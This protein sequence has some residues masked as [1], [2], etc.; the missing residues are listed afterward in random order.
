[1][2]QWLYCKCSNFYVLRNV[3]ARVNSR[4]DGE[5]AFFFKNNCYGV[6]GLITDILRLPEPHGSISTWIFFFFFFTESELS[7]QQEV[8]PKI[9]FWN[10]N[11]FKM[12]RFI[13]QMDFIYSNALEGNRI[14][15]AF[16]CNFA[17]LIY[18]VTVATHE[19]V[20]P[21]VT[22]RWFQNYLEEH[23]FGSCDNW[24]PWRYLWESLVERNKRGLGI[25]TT[26]T[27]DF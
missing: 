27:S 8:L 18:I 6:T 14:D 15:T 4:V 17:V 12:H 7:Q 10:P 13:F 5:D 16:K 9:F 19:T 2:F 1:M 3:Q 25:K 21:V 22:G 26:K 11:F 23:S 24:S 20:A